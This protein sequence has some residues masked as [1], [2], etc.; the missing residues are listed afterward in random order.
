MSAIAAVPLSEQHG[1]GPAL[2][3]AL[4]LGTC[5][6]VCFLYAMT[7]TIAN[8][9]LPQMQ[10]GTVKG[11][12]LLS[13]E[14]SALMPDLPT[15]QE[16]GLSDFEATSWSGL[17]LPKG[18]PAPIVKAGVEWLQKGATHYSPVPGVWDLRTAIA[19]HLS[20]HHSQKV[21]PDS[22]LVTPGAKM[23]TG[24]RA[25]SSCRSALRPDRTCAG[26]RRG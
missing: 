23:M 2:E 4:V 18:T 21:N 8:V 13:H 11:I 26:S 24:A 16:Q 14:R 17:F 20:S 6:V 22:V 3:R 5:T 12:A 10:G 25:A 9:S 1:A 7:V 19:E 15:A